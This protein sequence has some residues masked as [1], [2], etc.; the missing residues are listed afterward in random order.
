MLWSN[1]PPRVNSA[2]RPHAGPGA[3][4]RSLTRS[5]G[6][7]SAKLRPSSGSDA[8]ADFHWALVLA[9]SISSQWA[10]APGSTGWTESIRSNL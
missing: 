8:N 3:S 2:R 4:P 10:Y 5:M 6:A 9:L 7:R 1:A